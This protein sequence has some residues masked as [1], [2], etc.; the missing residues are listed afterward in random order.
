MTDFSILMTT[1]RFISD[2]NR[3]SQRSFWGIGP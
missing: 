1:I 3:F 2:S